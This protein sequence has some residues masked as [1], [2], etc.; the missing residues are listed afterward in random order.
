MVVVV[1][2][3]HFST[4]GITTTI[5]TST[6]PF[7]IVQVVLIAFGAPLALFVAAVAL[8]IFLAWLS[9]K[10]KALPERRRLRKQPD[11][12]IQPCP[13][14][15]ENCRHDPACRKCE[16]PKRTRRDETEKPDPIPRFLEIGNYVG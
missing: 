16:T 5:I 7:S 8:S 3:T 2:E 11:E 10:V 4:P 12:E 13:V 6:P 9:D 15:C 14:H 1:V